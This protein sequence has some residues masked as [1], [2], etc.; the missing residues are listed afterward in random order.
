[1][2]GEN[3]MNR[4]L[5]PKWRHHTVKMHKDLGK[6]FSQVCLKCP[7]LSHDHVITHV[8]DNVIPT[9]SG[10]PP[11]PQ[12]DPRGGSPKRDDNDDAWGRPDFLAH[13]QTKLNELWMRWNLLHHTYVAERHRWTR[14]ASSADLEL[15]HKRINHSTEIV[16]A[17]FHGHLVKLI[18]CLPRAWNK[19]KTHPC[20]VNL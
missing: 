13:G 17:T 3:R 8:T 6:N 12:A 19:D 11:P 18:R 4:I 15:V 5:L 9:P 16:T 2:Y 20:T 7:L 14:P 10:L 1:M